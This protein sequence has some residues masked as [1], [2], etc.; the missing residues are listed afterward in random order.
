MGSSPLGNKV[1]VEQL[2]V[3]KVP[4]DVS[5]T[6]NPG[7]LLKWDSTNHYVQP[8][9]AGDVGSSAVAATIVGVALDRQPIFSL[10]Q[11]LP[12]GQMN[13][14]AKGLVEFTV[15]DSA[16]YHAGDLVTL[17]AGPQLVRKTGASAANA[18]GVVAPENHFDASAGAPSGIVATALVTKMLIYLKPQFTDLTSW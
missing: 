6:I 7:D 11:N 17:G 4:V 18:I 1:K 3:S 5:K 12:F 15:D 2:R 14:L 10:N 16:T 9:V 8:T 13:V